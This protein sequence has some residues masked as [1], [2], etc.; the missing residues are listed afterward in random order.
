MATTIRDV[1]TAAGVSTATA[2]RALNGSEVVVDATRKR[3]VRVATELGYNP[4][5]VGRSLATGLTGNIGVILPDITNP[6][7]TSFLAELQSA[8]GQRE[9]GIM[10]GDSHESRERELLLVRQL[11]TQVDALVLASSRLADHSILETTAQLPVVLA[12][13]RLADDAPVVANLSQITIDVEPGFRE[14]VDHLSALGHRRISY[15]DGPVDS[16][17]AAQ[18]RRVISQVAT[19]RGMRVETVPHA[20]PDFTSGRQSALNIDLSAITAILSFNDHVALGVLSG[21]RERGIAVPARLSVVGCDDSLPHGMAWPALTTVDS[22]ARILGALAAE[23][24]L[25]PLPQRVGTVATSLVVRDSTGL[26]ASASV[27]SSA[28]KEAS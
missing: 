7:Y 1:A 15:F 25:H 8:L 24:I 14:A 18:K 26:A 22:S 11:A 2:S 16:W 13:R 21:L 4:S 17:S 5:R 9:I 12:N 28:P 27:Q 20:Q 19:E 23:A 10:I 3:V 6:F